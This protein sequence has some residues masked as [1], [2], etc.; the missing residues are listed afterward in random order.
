MGSEGK[1][2]NGALVSNV[3]GGL[4][5]AVVIWIVTQ[6][7]TEATKAELPFWVY[8]VVAGAVL[9]VASWAIP[10]WRRTIW[11]TVAAIFGWVFAIRPVTKA[12][13]SALVSTGYEQHK[14]EVEAERLT[15]RQ[16][17]WGF[18]AEDRLF[19]D[20]SMFWLHNHGYE[21]RDVRVAVDPSE[22]LTDGEVFFRGGFGSGMPGGIVGK[23]FRGATTDKGRDN[24]VTFTV[25]WRDA[26]DN[27]HDREVFMSPEEIRKGTTSATEEARDQGWKEG[28]SHAKEFFENKI[29]EE[30]ASQLAPVPSPAPRWMIAPE[31]TEEDNVFV[32]RN[33]VPRSVAREVRLEADSD[34]KILDA[35]QWKDLSGTDTT[36]AAGTFM[37]VFSKQGETFGV[38]LYLSWYDENGKKHGA[39]LFMSAP[40][41][42]STTV[43]TNLVI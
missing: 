37:A 26:N 12:Q 31:N 7:I 30:K 4:I 42:T 35:A 5:V 25:S 38:N 14:S 33:A 32:L 9:F 18:S 15:A 8:L 22:F 36:G 41:Q 34:L 1:W 19:G 3:L 43:S 23:H 13:R 27:G 17:R 6:M 21:A 2:Y 11:G 29:A 28:Y 10:L 20:M 39:N 40:D 24:G 16:P